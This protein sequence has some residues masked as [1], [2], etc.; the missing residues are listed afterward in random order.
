MYSPLGKCTAQNDPMYPYLVQYKYRM[1][2]TTKP[3]ELTHR[4]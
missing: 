4:L 1:Y 3:P 2:C